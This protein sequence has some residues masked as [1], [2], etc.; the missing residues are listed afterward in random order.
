[1][2]LNHVRLDGQLLPVLRRHL[3]PR[4]SSIHPVMFGAWSYFS[5][6]GARPERAGI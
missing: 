3:T 2:R 4:Y 5:F 6:V 1:M